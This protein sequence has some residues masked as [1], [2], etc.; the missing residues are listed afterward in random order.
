MKPPIQQ[1]RE[2]RWP[3]GAEQ[4]IATLAIPLDQL[5]AQAGL[6]LDHW[7]E[8]GLGP[9]RGAWCRLPSGRVVQLHDLEHMR[10]HRQTDDS[11]VSADLADIATLGSA[12]LIREV[13]HAFGLDSTAVAWRQD[14]SADRWAADVLSARR[15]GAPLPDPSNY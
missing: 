3:S 14:E 4:Q 7:E 6:T 9:A 13:L 10:M 8:D 5:A 1:V 2:Y 15:T 11:T 12:E